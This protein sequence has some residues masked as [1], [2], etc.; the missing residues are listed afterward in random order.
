MS[1]EDYIDQTITNHSSSFDIHFNQNHIQEIKEYIKSGIF[2]FQLIFDITTNTE[3]NNLY[4]TW[5]IKPLDWKSIKSQMVYHDGSP[6]GL[7]YSYGDVYNYFDRE[8]L[9]FDIGVI[10]EIKIEKL[11]NNDTINKSS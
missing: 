5:K 11:L 8:T 7:V 4:E 3:H 2:A 9:I 1:V 10:R 6:M